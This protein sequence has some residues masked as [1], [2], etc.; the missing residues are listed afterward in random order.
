MTASRE[1]T[2]LRWAGIVACCPAGLILIAWALFRDFRYPDDNAKGREYLRRLLPHHIGEMQVLL[3]L[4]MGIATMFFILL[5]AM[6]YTM[7]AGHATPSALVMASSATAFTAVTTTVCAIYGTIMLMGHGYP[8]FGTARPSDL[9]L[10]A[11]TWNLAQT[12]Y[13]LSAV[14]L[15]GAWS[16]VVVANRAH[17]VL[18]R[19]LGSWGAGIVAAINVGSAGSIFASTGP[20]SPGSSYTFGIQ[21]GTT[22][23]WMAIAGAALLRRTHTQPHGD[24]RAQ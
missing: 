20:W 1:V 3:V 12:L 9:V 18:P 24:T 2:A 4:L 14:L 21:A 22:Y 10:V 15:G 5:L 11:Y 8:Q 17:L 16:A 6:T 7:R 19:A 23:A 13:Q